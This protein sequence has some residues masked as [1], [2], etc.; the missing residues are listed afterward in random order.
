MSVLIVGANGNMASR[1]KA[2]LKA[3][4]ESFEGVDI[5][6][7]SNEILRAAKKA[8][9]VIITTPTETHLDLIELLAEAD[10]PILCEKPLSKDPK[11]LDHLLN[12]V[13]PDLQ[14]IFQYGELA[15]RLVTSPLTYYNYFKHGSDGLA[16]DCIQIIGLAKDQVVL[17]ED[18]PIW[19]CSING[20]KLN[21]SDMDKAYVHFI[22]KWLADKKQDLGFIRDIH[23][24]TDEIERFF[25]N[26]LHH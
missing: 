25:T 5:Q 21:L 26:G 9:R 24:K 16:W 10:I 11:R 13:K 8:D 4:G 19:K 2:I 7:T 6:H 20:K 22:R 12:I 17:Q 23:H 15:D 1:Y 3:L 14:M 18:S